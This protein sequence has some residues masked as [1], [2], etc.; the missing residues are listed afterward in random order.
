MLAALAHGILYESKLAA[1]DQG[2]D[3]PMRFVFDLQIP[4]CYTYC[5]IEIGSRTVDVEVP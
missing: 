5:G 3:L 1:W 2:Q 4:W